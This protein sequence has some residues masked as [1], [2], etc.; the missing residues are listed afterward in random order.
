MCN[1]STLCWAGLVGANAITI[2]PNGTAVIYM[3]AYG[4]S[5]GDFRLSARIESLN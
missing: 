2:G 4:S 3:A 5:T 1:G